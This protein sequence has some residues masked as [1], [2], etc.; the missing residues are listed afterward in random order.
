LSRG[1]TVFA[2]MTRALVPA[3]VDARATVGSALLSSNVVLGSLVF[4][5]MSQAP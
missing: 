1:T 3:V 4:L 2:T 5:V